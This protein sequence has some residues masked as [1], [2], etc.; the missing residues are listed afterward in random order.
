MG[1][2][3]H[4]S[5]LVACCHRSCHRSQRQQE[6]SRGQIHRGL[7]AAWGHKQCMVLLEPRD[8]RGSQG[9]G[10]LGGCQERGVMGTAG[11]CRSHLGLLEVTSS[12]TKKD[13]C[14]GCHLGPVELPGLTRADEHWQ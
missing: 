3:V 5:L 13:W 4:R 11:G 8:T 6:K 10:F 14:Q 7:P 12:G 2:W 1:V 9:P